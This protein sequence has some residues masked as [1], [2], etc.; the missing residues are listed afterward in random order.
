MRM[1]RV[2]LSVKRQTPLAVSRFSNNTVVCRGPPPEMLNS[3]CT[4]YLP[5]NDRLWSFSEVKSDATFN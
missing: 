5:N 2:R 3:N 1:N 4:Q